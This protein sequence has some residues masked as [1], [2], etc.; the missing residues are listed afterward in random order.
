MPTRRSPCGGSDER[1]DAMYNSLF[2]ELLTYMME[3]P[4]NI[5]LS[6]IFC[7]APRTSSA[8]A[9]TPPTSPRTSTTWCTAPRSPTT[10]RRGRHARLHADPKGRIDRPHAGHGPVVE[11][12]AASSSCCATILRPRASLAHAASGEEAEMLVV[13]G[14][15]RPHGA[16]LDA[17]GDLRYRVVPP[18]GVALRNQVRCRS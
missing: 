11:D 6:R 15:L 14:P 7:S 5:G 16:R 12:E 13:E 17:A 3:D 1:I 10:G 8:S 4:R 9:T 2:R 18:A